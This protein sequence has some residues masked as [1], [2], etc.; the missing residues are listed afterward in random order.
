MARATYETE[1]QHPCQQGCG[2]KR[3]G[4]P[5]AL[6]AFPDPLCLQVNAQSVFSERVVS[7]K[8]VARK[9]EEHQPL[10]EAVG[11]GKIPGPSGTARP[12]DR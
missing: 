11:H 7:R 4:A 12:W 8:H 5:G 10:L 3:A 9:V 2:V 1:I 6:H